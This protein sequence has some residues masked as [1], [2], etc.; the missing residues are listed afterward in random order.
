MNSPQTSKNS[1]LS[2]NERIKAIEER[3][4]RVLNPSR[5][6]ITDDSAKHI[7][8]PGHQ[9]GGHFSVDVQANVFIG[10]SHITC[11]KMVYA[12]VA[13][14]LGNEIHALQI[15]TSSAKDKRS[16]DNPKQT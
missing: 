1:K 13:D 2:P 8:H 4:R 6:I 12:A 10:K 15:H 7:G 3:I 16:S 14:L 11:H 9:G 5:L